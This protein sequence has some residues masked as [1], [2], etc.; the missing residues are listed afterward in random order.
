[1]GVSKKE[2]PECLTTFELERIT[3]STRSQVE[4]YAKKNYIESL[5]VS[6]MPRSDRLWDVNQVW[7]LRKLSSLRQSN[8]SLDDI[9]DIASKGSSSINNSVED[10]CMTQ[11]RKSRR[12]LKSLAYTERYKNDIARVGYR[13]QDPYL[14]YIP[15]RWMVLI[16]TS[17]IK[18]ASHRATEYT[19]PYANL[20]SL[21][22]VLGWGASESYGSI[23][24]IGLDEKSATSYFFIDLTSPPAN[25]LNHTNVADSGCYR[26]LCELPA[27][28]CDG[29]D[30]YSCSL[31]GR[32]LNATEQLTW[33]ILPQEDVLAKEQETENSENT[34]DETTECGLKNN[35]PSNTNNIECDFPITHVVKPRTML[36]ELDFPLGIVACAMPAGVYLCYQ[37]DEKNQDS[38]IDRFKGVL[39]FIEKR[40]LSDK[41]RQTT[42]SESA[43]DVIDRFMDET[44]LPPSGKPPFPDPLSIPSFVGD[45]KMEG[46]FKKIGQSEL[47][48]LILPVNAALEPENGYCM[49]FAAL[50]KTD[51]D[52][53]KRYEM[54]V[55]VNAEKIIT[56][57]GSKFFI[58]ALTLLTCLRAAGASVAP[59]SDMLLTCG[60][61]FRKRHVCGCRTHFLYA[62]FCAGFSKHLPRL[63]LPR[64]SAA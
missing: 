4:N 6:D 32:R 26:E 31:F 14:R 20:L 35:N 27:G 34:K 47:N 55:F 49:T 1:M 10:I 52:T 30:C 24:S 37:Y 41:D 16:P 58:C 63:N 18:D 39:P 2:H 50:P 13:E 28:G 59:V 40:E 23:T 33:N 5:R 7:A 42:D 48:N 51:D 17:E 19:H 9:A 8:L 60:G 54:Q 46:W 29:K 11:I 3:D 64:L 43:T 44:V 25:S 53:P 62:L 21:V 36:R 45:P 38:A 15:E 22:D 61:C 56:P 57:P 12:M